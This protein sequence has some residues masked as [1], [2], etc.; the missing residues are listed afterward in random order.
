MKSVLTF[1]M[2]AV[3]LTTGA[4]FAGAPTA[5]Q[6]AEF[7]SVCVGIS[8]DESLCTCKADAAMKLIDERMMT[9]VIAGMKGAGFHPVFHYVPLHLSPAGQRFARTHG[10]LPHTE[11]LSERLV[12][13]PMWPGLEPHMDAV[14]EAARRLIVEACEAVA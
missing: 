9:Y 10:E 13:L 14:I 8:G 7:K 2:L 1:G 11:A 5:A 6:K 3:V 12:R 4:A